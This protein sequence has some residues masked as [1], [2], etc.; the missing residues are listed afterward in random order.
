MQD[1]L[2]LL[3][4]ANFTINQMNI[5][6]IIYVRGEVNR[7]PELDSDPSYPVCGEVNFVQDAYVHYSHY[8]LGFA[9]LEVRQLDSRSKVVYQ[10]ERILDRVIV[11][12]GGGLRGHSPDMNA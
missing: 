11:V 4:F 8:S 1:T 5:Y 12:G 7:H 2:L 10:F 6:I 9:A 3:Q